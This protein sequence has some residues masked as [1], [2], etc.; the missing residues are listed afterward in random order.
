LKGLNSKFK[1]IKAF[2]L[3]LVKGELT[4]L[5]RGEASNEVR[6]GGWA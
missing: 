2:K 1:S 3:V 6:Q 5:E 4:T